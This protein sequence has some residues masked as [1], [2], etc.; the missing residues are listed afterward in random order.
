MHLIS[1]W[2]RGMLGRVFTVC[3]AICFVQ[4]LQAQPNVLTWH[5]DNARSGQNL[6]EAVLT[7]ANVKSSTFGR[8]FTITVDGKVDAQP[9]YVASLAIPGNGIHNVLLVATEHDSAY[10]FDA[11][12][13][14]QLWKVSVLGASET[15][16]DNRG[17]SQVTPEIGI[18]A[19]PAI[20]LQIGPHGT[21]YLIAMSKTASGAYLHRLHALDIATGAELFGGP[22]QITATYPGSGAEGSRTTQTFA[23]SQHKERPGLLISN[24]IVYTTWGSHCDAGPYT[25]W[26]MGYNESTLAQTSVLNLTPNGN[27]GGIWMSGAGPAADAAG[28]LYLLMG[29]GT[30]D[31]TLSGGFPSQGDYGNA[32]V[33]IQVGAN[34]KLSVA[35]YFTMDNT[36]SESGSDTDL[37][38]GGLMLLPPVNDSGGQSRSLIVGAGKDQNIYVVDSSNLGKFSPTADTIFQQMTGAAPGG[39]WSSPAWF[40]GTLYYGSVGANLR[41]FKFANGSFPLSPNSQSSNSFEYPGATPSI[42]ANGTQNAILWAAENS[43]PAVLH[44]YDA[45]NL[46]TELYNS[47]QAA[48]GRDHFGAGNKYIVPTVANG[49]VYVGTTNGV[50]VFG[51]LC[52]YSIL[53]TQNSFLVAGGT[54]QVSVTA[55]SGCPWSAASNA[56]WI[57]VTSGSSGT[58]SGTVGYSIMANS[59]SAGR[60]GTLTIAGQTFTVTQAGASPVSAISRVGIFRQGFLWILDANGNEQMDIP[61]D[62]VYAFG[63]IPGD[64]PITGDWNG[65]GH[66]KIG[67]Y[68]PSNGLFILDTNGD[69]VLD[70]GD[71]VFN[72]HIGKSPGD[73][74]VTGDWN[75][76]GRTKVGYFRQGFLWI[77]DTNGDGLFEQGSDQV[78]AFGGVAGDVPVVGDWTGTGASKI[79]VVRQGFLWVLDANGNGTF[80]GTGPGEDLVFPFGGIPGDVPL[81]GDW[82]GNGITEVGIFRQGFLWVLDANGDRQMDAGDYVFGYGGLP[83]D[84]PVV[85]KW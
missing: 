41:A 54:G 55:T 61:P 8:L 2:V 3:A 82:N 10:A 76:D 23:A 68:R 4:T 65:D 40:N 53:P 71:S 31:T 1:Q 75:G 44:A 19:T 33:K 46:A 78:F 52:S 29:N 51:L 45:A 14:A 42:S 17:C 39:V 6:Q 13:G 38:S 32:F 35:D 81:T 34:G 57:T 9:L 50:G 30:F 16:S 26:V 85:G 67:I 37:G 70:A 15:S 24:G 21:M 64:I 18:T 7:P 74:P 79:G 73:I 59:G 72:L 5:N 47:N 63:G 20:D 28:N 27:D 77:L 60:T 48:N 49:K 58:G 66:T 12:T 69:G 11:D 25:G 84:K 43:S 62:L 36:T 80:D 83:G 56:A 22:V